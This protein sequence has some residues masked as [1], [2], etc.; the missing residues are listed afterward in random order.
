MHQAFA[1]HPGSKAH[2]GGPQGCETS[3][4]CWAAWD[5]GLQNRGAAGVQGWSWGPWKAQGGGKDTALPLPHRPSRGSLVLLPRLGHVRPNIR[6]SP[7]AGSS[8]SQEGGEGLII[9]GSRA[10]PCQRQVGEARG[11]GDGPTVPSHRLVRPLGPG[12]PRHHQTGSPLRRGSGEG[13]LPRHI[14]AGPLPD[15]VPSGQ[16]LSLRLSFLLLPASQGCRPG[17]GRESRRVGFTLTP[18]RAGRPGR[19]LTRQGRGRTCGPQSTSLGTL[20]SRG[21]EGGEGEACM[22]DKQAFPSP[23]LGSPPW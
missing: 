3:S 11:P 13:Q 8:G 14:P 12:P 9:S 5:G 22:G 17:L 23:R 18:G 7:L 4:P 10:A 21:W 20:G 1:E 2:A 6:G 19:A 16:R 15:G